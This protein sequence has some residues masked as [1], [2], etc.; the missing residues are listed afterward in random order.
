MQWLTSGGPQF[1]Y[2]KLTEGQQTNFWFFYTSNI[3]VKKTLLE[4]HNF[5]TDFQT[6]G[7]EDI[8]LAYRLEKEGMR[9]HYK[10]AALAHHDHQMKEASLKK[11]MIGIGKN[12]KVFQ[13]KHPELKIVPSFTKKLAFALMGSWP[14]LA[15]ARII[16]KRFF[17]YALSKRYFLQGLN[18]Q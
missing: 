3:S 1:A 12:A 5:D 14:G 18:S 17:W 7:W 6:Y 8:E 11:R 9:I 2:H 10:P 4:Q 15:L 16:G 13:N